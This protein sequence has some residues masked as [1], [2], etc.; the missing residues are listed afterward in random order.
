[1]GRTYL[2]G[3]EMGLDVAGTLCFQLGGARRSMTWRHTEGRKSGV[4][5][6]RCHFIRC[7]AHHFGLAWVSSGLE[8]QQVATASALEAA[9]PAVDESARLI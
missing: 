5:S 4:R 1:M 2:F 9:A 8:R 7:L 6:S 3:D